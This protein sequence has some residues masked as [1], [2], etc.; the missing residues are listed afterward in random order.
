MKEAYRLLGPSG[1]IIVEVPDMLGCVHD[2]LKGNA[3]IIGRIFSADRGYQD[4]HRWGY[5]RS[6]LMMIARLAGFQW[7]LT[8]GG[9]DYHSIQIPTIRLESGRG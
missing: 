4:S 3:G 9:T 2:Y 1:A 8:K 6:S 5:D 7:I